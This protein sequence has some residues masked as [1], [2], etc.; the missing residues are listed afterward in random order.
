MACGLQD[1]LIGANRSIAEAL[2]E[3]GADVVYEECDGVHDWYFW[4]EYI[5]HV[6]KWLDVPSCKKG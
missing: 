5:R 2:R 1:P 4:D 3:A 6:L